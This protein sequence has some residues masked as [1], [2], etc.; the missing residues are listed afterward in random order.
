MAIK[1]NK[2]TKGTRKGRSRSGYF[3]RWYIRAAFTKIRVNN[4]TVLAKYA[5]SSKLKLRIKIKI[6]TL[7]EISAKTGVRV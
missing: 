1:G 5:K 6:I 2:G 7:T 4:K 3:R